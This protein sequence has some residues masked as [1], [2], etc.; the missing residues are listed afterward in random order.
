MKKLLLFLGLAMACP[1]L[2]AQTAADSAY[3]RQNHD[4]S[5]RTTHIASK[6]NDTSINLN[7]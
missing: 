3:I 4:I 2:F 6:S 7:Q 5:P 1:R